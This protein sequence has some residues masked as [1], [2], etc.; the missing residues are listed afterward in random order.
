[1]QLVLNSDSYQGGVKKIAQLVNSFAVKWISDVKLFNE[2][3]KL[4]P[5]NIF[6]FALGNM[7]NDCLYARGV[8][9]KNLFHKYNSDIQNGEESFIF[10]QSIQL[11]TK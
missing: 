1:M 2:L 10:W 6:M 8:P 5:A 9:A 4:A 11:Y 3:T 7:E